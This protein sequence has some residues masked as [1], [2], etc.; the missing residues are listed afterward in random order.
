MDAP[1]LEQLYQA[2]YRAVHSYVLSLTHN[3][4]AAEDITQDAFLRYAKSAHKFRGECSEVTRLCGIA[5]NLWID[6]C[7]RE[8]R[9]SP[10]SH[11]DSPAPGPDLE[12]ALADAS[13]ALRIHQI[14]HTLPEPYKEVFTLRVFGELPF[15]QIAQLF[16]KTESWARVTYY[17]AKG[18]IQSALQAEER[19]D[20]S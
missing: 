17:R 13:D 2:H 3:P 5:K 6:Q 19:S 1:T 12:E 8:K 7:R 20:P 18:K 9:L 11:Q 4:A 16:G 10:L 15:G 14:L